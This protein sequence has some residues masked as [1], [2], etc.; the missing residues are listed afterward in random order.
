M[1]PDSLPLGF[2]VGAVAGFL[3]SLFGMYNAG[4]NAHVDHVEERD[5]AK[6]EDNARRD[7]K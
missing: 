1:P 7:R 3:V 5:V 6:A 2:L 4:W